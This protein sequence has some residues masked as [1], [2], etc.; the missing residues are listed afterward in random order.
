VAELIVR[1]QHAYVRIHEHRIIQNRR[2]VVIELLLFFV[3]LC[4]LGAF[5]GQNS[6]EPV[7]LFALYRFSRA[8]SCSSV[9]AQRSFHVGQVAIP[10]TWLA[11]EKSLR[12]N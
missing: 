3:A 1:R 9:R 2:G 10:S 11:A 4:I 8:G 6:A 5:F 12:Q 7:G